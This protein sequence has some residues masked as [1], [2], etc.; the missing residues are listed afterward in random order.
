MYDSTTVR[1]P[2]AE[3]RDPEGA[4][5]PTAAMTGEADPASSGPEGADGPDGNDPDGNDPDGN[6][7]D[8]DG[9][10]LG[11]AAAR[12]E[13]DLILAELSVDDLDV[14][15]LAERVERASAL[16]E[17]CRGRIANARIQVERVTAA[18][19]GPGDQT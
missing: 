1:R 17:I 7:P 8:G 13:L 4:G 15:V 10:Q 14:D 5:G 2:P 11:Y 9:A 6:D 3:S 12:A 16:I 18:A 19:P